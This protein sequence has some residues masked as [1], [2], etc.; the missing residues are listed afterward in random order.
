M[1]YINEHALGVTK[2]IFLRN[3]SQIGRIWPKLRY[4]LPHLSLFLPILCS[5]SHETNTVT[6]KFTQVPLKYIKFI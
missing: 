4:R 5:Y 6:G 2:W 1:A 3:I